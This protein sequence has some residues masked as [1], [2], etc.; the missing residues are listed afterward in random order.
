[1]TALLAIANIILLAILI[2]V[3]VAKHKGTDIRGLVA[4]DASKYFNM[5]DRIK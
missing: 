4:A 2:L 3:T 1:M 5:I